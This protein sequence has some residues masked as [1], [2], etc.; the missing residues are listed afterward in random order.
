MTGNVLALVSVFVKSIPGGW[1]MPACTLK[2]RRWFARSPKNHACATSTPVWFRKPSRI[3]RILRIFA[4]NDAFPKASQ[5]YGCG[6]PENA[7]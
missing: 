7:S 4:K 2:C 3:K 5:G 1:A 6:K